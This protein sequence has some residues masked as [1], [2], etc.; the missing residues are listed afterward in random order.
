MLSSVVQTQSKRFKFVKN[1]TGVI[2]G[3]VADAVPAI[4]VPAIAVPNIAV[5]NIAAAA[6]WPT[7]SQTQP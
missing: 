6:P 5:P 3:G 4:A 2:S 7:I 1:F